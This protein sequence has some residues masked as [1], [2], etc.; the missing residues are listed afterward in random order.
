VVGKK[1]HITFGVDAKSGYRF[2]ILLLVWTSKS[3]YRFG[4]LAFGVDAKSGYCFGSL[5]GN[6]RN[7]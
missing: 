3:G 5:Y 2:G 6:R 7:L 1:I 4:I